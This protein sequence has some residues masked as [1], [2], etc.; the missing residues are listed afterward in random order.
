MVVSSI[1]IVLYVGA[2]FWAASWLIRRDWKFIR[3]HYR[4]NQRRTA[5]FLAS[6]KI[7]NL[8][9]I[10]AIFLIYG[11]Y[12]LHTAT[13]IWSF[14]LILLCL[15][16]LPILASFFL[17]DKIFT[18]IEPKSTLVKWGIAVIV[19]LFAWFIKAVISDELNEIFP[20]DPGT[21]PV[22]LSTGIFLAMTGFCA[23]YLDDQNRLVQ[24]SG[25]ASGSC[26]R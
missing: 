23:V 19:G 26:C 25:C 3:R 4:V 2:N 20:F 1:L 21:M 13:T 10:V 7:L 8:S 15:G 9:V 16:L 14:S 24:Q 5:R 6:P 12:Q 11:F 17:F 22:A 18:S